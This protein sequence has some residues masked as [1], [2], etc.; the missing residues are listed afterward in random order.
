MSW[1]DSLSKLIDFFRFKKYSGCW[2]SPVSKRN[3]LKY[4]TNIEYDS[5]FHI[6]IFETISSNQNSFQ[7]AAYKPFAFSDKIGVGST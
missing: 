7:K 4:P 3:L 2:P 1:M 6:P 5:M